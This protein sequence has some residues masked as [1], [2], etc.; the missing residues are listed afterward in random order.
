[1]NNTQIIRGEIR[2]RLNNSLTRAAA[3][4]NEL[5]GELYELGRAAALREILDFISELS[6]E[7][8]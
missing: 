2:E 4:R 3:L 5:S 6:E 8:K 1:M 7:N